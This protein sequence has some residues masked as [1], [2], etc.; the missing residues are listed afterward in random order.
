MVSWRSIPWPCLFTELRLVAHNLE[1]DPHEVDV[2]R[3]TTAEALV[4]VKRGVRYAMIQGS[5]ELRVIC[6]KGLHSKD[7]TP[8]LKS[9]IINEL[10]TYVSSRNSLRTLPYHYHSKYHIAATEDPKNAGV[11]VIKMPQH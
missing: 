8:V 2:H 10:K 9:A 3:L 5:P 6:G 11:L 1:R 7:K 4:K